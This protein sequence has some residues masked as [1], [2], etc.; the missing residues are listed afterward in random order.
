MIGFN[1][2]Y[3]NNAYVEIMKYAIILQR[4]NLEM[5]SLHQSEF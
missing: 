3:S 2:N 1:K 5:Q 4:R